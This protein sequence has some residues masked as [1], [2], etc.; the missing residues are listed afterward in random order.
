MSTVTPAAESLNRRQP[1]PNEPD[2]LDVVGRQVQSLKFGSVHITV[3]EGRVV[4]VETTVRV[5]F[6]KPQ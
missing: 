1:P 6:D 3:H 5:R 4:Q 2:W